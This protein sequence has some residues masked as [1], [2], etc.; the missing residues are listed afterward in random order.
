MNKPIIQSLWIGEKLSPMELMSINSFIKNG[1]EFHLYIYNDIPNIPKGTIVKN[2]EDILPKDSI[3][4]YNDDLSKSLIGGGSV[5]AF[6]NLFRYKL[7][8]DKGNYWTDLDMVCLKYF[9]FQDKYVFS[10][11]HELDTNETLINAGI[12]K[13]PPKCDFIKYCYNKVLN[14]NKETVVWGQIGPRLVREAVINYNLND[15]VKPPSYFCPIP[16]DQTIRIVNDFSFNIQYESYC[17]H[18]WNECWRRSNMD[19]N[20]QHNRNSLYEILKSLYL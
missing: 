4:Y 20:T 3:F 7:L 14:T 6:S 5:S 18:L 17:I 10:S 9:D 2:G 16:Y 11:E 13:C 19:K 15:Y 12:I 8:H 1:N